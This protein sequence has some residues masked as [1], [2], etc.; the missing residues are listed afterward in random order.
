MILNP[1]LVPA[2][3]LVTVSPSAGAD[4]KSWLKTLTADENTTAAVTSALSDS[5]IADGLRAALG[6]GVKNAVSQLGREDGFLANAKVRIPVP[7]HLKLVE[8][9]LRKIGKEEVA[10]QF[11]NNLNRAAERAVPEAA[12]VFAGAISKMTIDDARGILNGGDTAATEFLKRSSNDELKGR[13]APIVDTAVRHAGATR[14]Y[15]E[16][17]DK[18][19]PAAR[20]VDTEKL[21]LT[22]YVTDRALDGL[23]QVIGAEEAKIR[24]NPAAR[25][26]DLLKKVFGS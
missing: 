20:F 13:F 25:T 18:A 7:E 24:A 17:L 10:D 12:D 19:G 22:N 2:L 4:W 6:K 26:T 21:D 15:Q 8:S 11:V 14:S 3:V 9:G 16:L 1:W 23:Y 5:E